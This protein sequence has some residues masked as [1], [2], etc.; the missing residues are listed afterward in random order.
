MLAID[1]FL[2]GMWVGILAVLVWVVVS[3]ITGWQ[4]MPPLTLPVFLVVGLL[5]ALVKV[6]RNL[7]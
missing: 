3:T 2:R 1:G 6:G 5:A 4:W 7:P